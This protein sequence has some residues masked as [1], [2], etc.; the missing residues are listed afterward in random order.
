MAVAALRAIFDEATAAHRRF[1]GQGLEGVAAAAAAISRA[2]TTGR[3][4]LAFGNGGARPM[5]S[6]WSPNWSDDS[7]ASARRWPVWPSRPLPPA[8]S[9]SYREACDV[10]ARR[11]QHQVAQHD[12]SRSRHTEA[13]RH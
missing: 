2:V 12:T 9:A 8:G 11:A 13:P 7:K 4:V 5:P 1:A 6:I 10:L 3:K